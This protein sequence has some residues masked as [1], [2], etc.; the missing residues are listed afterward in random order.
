MREGVAAKGMPPR[1]YLAHDVR[2]S[3]RFP[4]KQ[5]KSRLR[6]M[7][8]EQ[9]EHSARPPWVRSIVEGE[10]DLP[11]TEQY[12]NRSRQRRYVDSPFNAERGTIT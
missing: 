12:L 6:A 3:F 1:G 8:I 4:A 2:I 10:Y 11:V 5:E 9:V 7:F